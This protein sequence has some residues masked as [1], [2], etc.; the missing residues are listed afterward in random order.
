MPKPAHTRV[1]F[2][3]HI[4]GEASILEIFSFNLCFPPLDG[5]Y[6]DEDITALEAMAASLHTAFGTHLNPSYGEDTWLDRTRVAT[7]DGDGLVERTAEGAYV[8]GDR[9]DPFNGTEAKQPMPL[10]T[11][12]CV[13][14]GTARAGATGKGRFFLPWMAMS[15][16]PDDKRINEATAIATLNGIQDFLQ[17]CATGMGM[18]PVVVSSKGYM[19]E[20]TT[21]RLGRV[22]DTMRSRRG[23]V[24]EGYVSV[25]LHP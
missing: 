23:D 11:A 8:Q 7:V 2:S 16:D 4:G 17:D 9:N 3:G 13:S 19:S 20:V 12:L 24:P 22:P 25:A 10:Q 5:P 14:L 15:L 6:T 18:D 21:I 1:T